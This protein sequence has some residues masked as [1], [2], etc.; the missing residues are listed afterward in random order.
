M[1]PLVDC[2]G[3]LARRPSLS[4]RFVIVAAIIGLLLTRVPTQR[5]PKE[6]S[7]GPNS[8]ASAAPLRLSRQSSP[9]Q[10]HRPNRNNSQPNKG[11]DDSNSH[12]RRHEATIVREPKPGEQFAAIPRVAVRSAD[13]E[14]MT[15]MHFEKSETLLLAFQKRASERTRHGD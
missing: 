2:S 1:L 12:H 5:E 13:A 11:T 8:D 10:K 4:Q 15:A 7:G 6:V 3:A 14:T 9:N